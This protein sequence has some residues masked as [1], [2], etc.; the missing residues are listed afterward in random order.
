MTLAWPANGSR[1]LLHLPGH[2]LISLQMHFITLLVLGWNE[3]TG[4]TQLI[5]FLKESSET[6]GSIDWR[7]CEFKSEGQE[8]PAAAAAAAAAD[9]RRLIEL[10]VQLGSWRRPADRFEPRKQTKA[11]SNLAPSSA[12]K[13]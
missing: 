10:M 5:R 4:E 8:T 9:L 12:L 7:K 6:M 3:P 11:R 1:F 13:G 2:F